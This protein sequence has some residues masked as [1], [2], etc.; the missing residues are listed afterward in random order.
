MTF[1]PKRRLSSPGGKSWEVGLHLVSKSR[2]GST[3]RKNT[4]KT[5][6]LYDDVFVVF[7]FSNDSCFTLFCIGKHVVVCVEKVLSADNASSHQLDD[8]QLSMSSI[9]Q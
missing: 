6:K 3:S 4:T 8:R 7:F 1:I 9:W 2:G 5:I